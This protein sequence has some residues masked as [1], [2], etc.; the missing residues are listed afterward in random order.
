MSY[1]G[2][3]QAL[4][5]RYYIHYLYICVKSAYVS[6]REDTRCLGRLCGRVR[7]AVCSLG[8]IEALLRRFGGAIKY[9]Y[10]LLCVYQGAITLRRYYIYT[11]LYICAIIYICAFIHIKALLYICTAKKPAYFVPRYYPKPTG[12]VHVAVCSI[13]RY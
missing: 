12:Y 8:R 5:T 7:L 10:T 3:I 11:P 13:G 2:F 9:I 1:S 4:L 6:L